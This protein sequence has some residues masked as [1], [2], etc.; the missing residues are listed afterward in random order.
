MK[1]DYKGLR[2][3]LL[4]AVRGR[5]S[6]S[7]VSKK[8]GFTFNQVHKWESGHTA[9]TWKD[10]VR[11]CLACGKDWQPVL[12]EHL[13]Y[14][15]T[16]SNA[17]GLIRHL[18]GA[19]GPSDLARMT[20]YS[21]FVASKWLSGKT[22]PDLIVILELFDQ[23]CLLTEVLS[24]IL[25][26]TQLSSL[27]AEYLSRKAQKEVF[28]SYPWVLGLPSC[29]Y[30]DT[31]KNAPHHLEGFVAEKLA[32]PF[33]QEKALLAK[34]VELDFLK[35]ENGKYQVTEKI[36]DTRGDLKG[37]VALRSFWIE[38]ILRHIKGLKAPTTQSLFPMFVFASSRA[39]QKK[40]R[41][42]HYELYSRLRDLLQKDTGPK[43]CVTVLSTQLTDL[44]ECLSGL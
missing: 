20:G 31:Y 23:A 28:Y 37:F 4:V 32:V 40:V 33:S 1:R 19:E 36:F 22:Q 8:L 10:F 12:N 41:E 38:R 6:Q 25:G 5:R 9:I 2:R 27:K 24:V 34:L 43:D 14:T 3:E 11:L 17:S 21:R 35:L 16:P 15:K 30:L 7:H 39:T 44:E 29:L 42:A 26:G 18:T 13:G